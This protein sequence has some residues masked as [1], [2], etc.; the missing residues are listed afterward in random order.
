VFKRVVWFSIGAAAGA[1]GVV[2]AEQQ[3]RRKLDDLGPDHV[4]TLAG[5]SARR[6]GRSV[7]DAVAEGRAVA[8]DTE[9]ELR[10]RRDQRIRDGRMPSD[11]PPGVT[12]RPSPR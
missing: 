4:V 7:L 8:A 1:S 2:W 12:R 9:D 10:A 6:V 11:T 5:R 3:I